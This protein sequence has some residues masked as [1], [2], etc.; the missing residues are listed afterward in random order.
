MANGP[1]RR[2]VVLGAGFSGGPRSMVVDYQNAMRIVSKHGKPDV[3]LTF[4]CKG[5]NINT[6]AD[7]DNL[8]SAEL[9]CRTEDPVL[10]DI[11]SKNV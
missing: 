1:P 7:V 10:F 4:T 9:P 5:W 2:R 6:S 3:F 11:V 8:I